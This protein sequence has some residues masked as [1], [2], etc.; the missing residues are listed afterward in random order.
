[1][2]V[3]APAQY[4]IRLLLPFHLN[5]TGLDLRAERLKRAEWVGTPLWEQPDKLHPKY[6]D[7]ILPGASAFL[8]PDG[9]AG[10]SYFRVPA[11]LLDS[12]FRSVIA[13]IP[14]GA[15]EE[16][17]RQR[18]GAGRPRPISVPVSLE[19]KYGIELFVVHRRIGAL[20]ICFQQ[21]V[22]PANAGSENLSEVRRIQYH[23]SQI[24]YRTPVFRV[25]HPD[26]DGFAP[27]GE[28]LLGQELWLTDPLIDRLGTAGQPFTLVELCDFLIRPI[29]DSIESLE[30]SQFIVHTVLR[31]DNQTSFA[32][33]SRRDDYT[34][35]LAGFAQIEEPDHAPAVPDCIG[36]PNEALN[37]KHL[38]AYSYL[39]G[40]HFVA[41]QWPPDEH[42]S[43][44]DARV[45]S[46]QRKY[47]VAFL[48]TLANRLVAHSFLEEAVRNRSS[49]AAIAGIWDRF[50]RFEAAGQLIDISRREAV[51]RCYRLAQS[52]QRIPETLAS[53]HKIFRDA[54]ASQY[55]DR[56]AEQTARQVQLTEQQSKI[57]AAQEV[58]KHRLGLIEVFIV[59]VYTAELVHIFGDTAEFEHIY[60]FAGVAVLSLLALITVK[61]HH[62][63]AAEGTREKA[64]FLVACWIA[65]VLWL[66]GGFVLKFANVL[67]APGE[68]KVVLPH[69]SPPAGPSEPPPPAR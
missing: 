20:S 57:L 68:P 66:G 8:F 39:G 42:G 43:Y 33:P 63:H 61:R 50:T 45:E 22:R 37:T 23:L 69:P 67:K 10:P 31:F 26:L 28:S 59:T 21:P 14:D 3:P 24:L 32:D 15:K 4:S 44:D 53:L 2:S 7:E 30:Q 60:T 64:G 65:L 5:E 34:Q 17:A 51:N 9:N 38:A 11:K 27:P 56:L 6:T 25:P 36:L 46:V 19:R 41:D 47:F 16:K 62:D 48:T 55:A 13:M 35:Q 54:Q 58:A 1:M 29:R 40:A 49:N 12:W 18:G 52:A